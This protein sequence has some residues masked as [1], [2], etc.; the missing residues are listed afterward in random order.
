MQSESLAGHGFAANA[1]TL[2]GLKKC[3]TVKTDSFEK[4]SGLTD[5]QQLAGEGTGRRYS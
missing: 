5:S 3:D 2:I 1:T 4:Q